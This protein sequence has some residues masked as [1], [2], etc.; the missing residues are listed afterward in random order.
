MRASC[1]RSSM[2]WAD[3]PGPVHPRAKRTY[4][5]D[6]ERDALRGSPGRWALLT[7][8][9]S[10]NLAHSLRTKNPGYEFRMVTAPNGYHTYARYV[11]GV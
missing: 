5:T 6:A 3:P 2:E 9:G 1:G 11:G 4:F 7:T 8:E 10:R